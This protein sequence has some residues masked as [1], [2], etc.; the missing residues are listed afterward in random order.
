MGVW[1]FRFRGWGWGVGVSQADLVRESAEV[2]LRPYTPRPTPHT[3]HPTPHTLH[4]TPHTLHPTPHTLHP[5]P[6]TSNPKPQT[7]NPTPQI[8]NPKPQTPNP[9]TGNRSQTRTSGSHSTRRRFPLPSKNCMV[10]TQHNSAW[11]ELQFP[12][13]LTYFPGENQLYS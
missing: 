10:Q 5:T 12:T 1:G 4:P 3:L 8:T 6:Q 13:L 2:S 7:P 11:Q 9:Q